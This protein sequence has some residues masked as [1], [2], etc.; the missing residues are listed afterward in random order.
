[1][2][3]S[4]LAKCNSENYTTY[5]KNVL[6]MCIHANVPIS[7]VTRPTIYRQADNMQIFHY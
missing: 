7:P 2:T 5:D 3:S 4:P 1:M 6:N